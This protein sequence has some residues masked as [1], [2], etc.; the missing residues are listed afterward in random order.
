MM[1]YNDVA[2]LQTKLRAILRSIEIIVNLS[3]FQIQNYTNSS[4]IVGNI[5]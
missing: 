5:M 3:T 2:L 1:S 4:L